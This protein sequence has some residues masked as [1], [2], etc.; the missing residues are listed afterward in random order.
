M[1]LCRIARRIM[2]QIAAVVSLPFPRFTTFKKREEVQ[3]DENKKLDNNYVY[4][5][6]NDTKLI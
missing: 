1:R 5:S 2:K 3:G 6:I 4:A